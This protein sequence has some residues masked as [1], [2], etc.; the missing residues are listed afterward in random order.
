MQHDPGSI[1][2]VPLPP[3][4]P[5]YR[6]LMAGLTVMALGMAGLAL[7]LLVQLGPGVWAWFWSLDSLV[8]VGVVCGALALAGWIVAVSSA[9]S[10]TQ[11]RFLTPPRPM[12]PPV[13]PVEEAPR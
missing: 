9:M 8:A 6:T 11:L 5:F 4:P 13:P 12:P 2:E 3:D 7:V 1:V 10:A